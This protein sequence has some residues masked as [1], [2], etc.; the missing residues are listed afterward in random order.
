MWWW[1]RTISWHGDC[2][3]QQTTPFALSASAMPLPLL[4]VIQHARPRCVH[5][6]FPTMLLR[7]HN[8]S[9]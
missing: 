8:E 6:S 1:R 4:L 2:F 9:Y 5:A 3:W 7:F